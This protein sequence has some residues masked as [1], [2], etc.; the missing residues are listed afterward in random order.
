VSSLI[1][2]STSAAAMSGRFGLILTRG[3]STDRGESSDIVSGG[4]LAAGFSTSAVLVSAAALL[5]FLMV[6]C[7]LTGWER[8]WTCF[9]PFFAQYFLNAFDRHS[10]VMQQFFDAPQQKHICRAVVTSTACTFYGLYL[11]K[12][13][14][15]K[16]KHMGRGI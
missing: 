12:P 16:T 8:D 7:R 2:G 6:T 9:T 4:T 1:S 5:F 13:A 14:F 10:A 15:P 11:R 3:L